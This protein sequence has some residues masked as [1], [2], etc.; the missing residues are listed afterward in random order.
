MLWSPR[1]W[2]L[3]KE[4]RYSFCPVLPDA[5]VTLGLGSSTGRE[6]VLSP[7]LPDAGHPG[8]GSA[9][10][11]DRA[12]SPVLLDAG[13]PE[14]WVRVQTERILSLVL[15]DAGSSMSSFYGVFC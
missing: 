10:G 8:L 14:G 11:R 4:E 1:D 13:H 12:F 9:T 15:P 2:A 6:L 7:I 3:L 5:V